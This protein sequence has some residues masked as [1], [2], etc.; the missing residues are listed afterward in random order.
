MSYSSNQF[1]SDEAGS[2][3]AASYTKPPRTDS[4][5][6]AKS[7]ENPEYCEEIPEIEGDHSCEDEDVTESKVDG[8]LL[9]S[10]VKTV[11]ENKDAEQVDDANHIGNLNEM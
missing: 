2:S 5:F 6:S 4:F 8:N 1:G 9:E 7:K 3:A 10:S 11:T